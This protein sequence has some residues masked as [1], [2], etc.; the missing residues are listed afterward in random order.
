MS[1]VKIEF[2]SNLDTLTYVTAQNRSS[3]LSAFMAYINKKLYRGFRFGAHTQIV[4]VLIPVDFCFPWAIFG[5]LVG[6]NTRKGEL[7]ELPAS[8]TWGMSFI[9]IRSLPLKSFLDFFSKCLAIS[10][11]KLVYALSSL[12]NILRSCFTRMGSLW[13]SSCSYPRHS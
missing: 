11:W 6:N 3:N 9:R 5:P 4:S 10:T 2:N 8:D 7:V 13:P 1:H 12:H